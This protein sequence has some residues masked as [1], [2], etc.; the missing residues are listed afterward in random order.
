MNRRM[1]RQLTPDERAYVEDQVKHGKPE[2]LDIRDFLAAK[3]AAERKLAR[4]AVLM[5][6][7]ALIVLGLYR[8][9][10]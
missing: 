6:V 5:L 9:L 3:R 10:R 2:D 1:P 4:N 8:W 7:V